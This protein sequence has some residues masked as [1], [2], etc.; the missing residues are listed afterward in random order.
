M[1]LLLKPVLDEDLKTTGS[2]KL[3][4]DLEMPLVAVLAEM[5]MEGIGLD[6]EFLAV[7]SQ[8]LEKDITG[9]EKKIY[10]GVGEEFNLNSPKQLSEA[11]FTTLGV[12]TPKQRCKDC[13]WLLFDCG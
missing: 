12:N 8:K 10:K 3:F 9:L 6:T 4:H 7:M 2:D 1:V 5:E 11:L 13:K